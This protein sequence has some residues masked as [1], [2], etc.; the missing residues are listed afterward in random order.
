M[1]QA[2]WMPTFV[3]C[4]QELRVAREGKAMDPNAGSAELAPIFSQ[5]SFQLSALTNPNFLSDA[6]IMIGVRIRSQT[7]WRDAV[8]VVLLC[9]SPVHATMYQT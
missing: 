9:R 3:A 6:G 8:A 4:L 1:Q 7:H 5:T 2:V